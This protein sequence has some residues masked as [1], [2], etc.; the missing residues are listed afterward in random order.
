MFQAIMGF[1]SER[2][3]GSFVNNTTTSIIRL[4]AGV[5]TV[6][7]SSMERERLLDVYRNST[8]KSTQEWYRLPQASYLARLQN[9]WNIGFDTKVIVKEDEIGSW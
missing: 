6:M 3:A 9:L 8:E 4:N 5:T 7:L 2:K 1:L